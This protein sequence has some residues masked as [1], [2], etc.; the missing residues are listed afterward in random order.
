[1]QLA[2]INLSYQKE[3][4]SQT[5]SAVVVPTQALMSTSSSSRQYFS[6]GPSL[7]KAIAC[8][9]MRTQALSSNLRCAS[10]ALSTKKAIGFRQMP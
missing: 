9:Q 8:F 2:R 6:E 5:I 10:L 7:A 3:K 4:I 1:M